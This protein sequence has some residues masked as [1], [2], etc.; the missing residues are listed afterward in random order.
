MLPTMQ[1]VALA[2]ALPDGRSGALVRGI[3]TASH[4]YSK[5]DFKATVVVLD[6]LGGIPR[7]AAQRMLQM[8]SLVPDDATRE[9][10]KD[11]LG[12]L[13]PRC[14]HTICDQIDEE[15]RDLKILGV[16]TMG[17]V[18]QAT[19]TDGRTSVYKVVNVE[20]RDLVS[21]D[22]VFLQQFDGMYTTYLKKIF[23][24]FVSKEKQALIESARQVSIPQML[25]TGADM[26][27]AMD[28]EYEA[29]AMKCFFENV[30][31]FVKLPEL[32]LSMPELL[33][34]KGGVV[35]EMTPVLGVPLSMRNS[36]EWDVKYGKGLVRLFVAMVHLGHVH[37]ELHAANI[38]VDKSKFSLVDFGEVMEL[39]SDQRSWCLALLASSVKVMRGEFA[40]DVEVDTDVLGML[41]QKV[42]YRL[43]PM[44][45]LEELSWSSGT[46][47]LKD[48]LS[49]RAGGETFK[50][51][52]VDDTGRPIYR[53]DSNELRWDDTE[54]WTFKQSVGLTSGSDGIFPPHRDFNLQSGVDELMKFIWK[55]AYCLSSPYETVPEHMKDDIL[56][57][58]ALV[59]PPKWLNRFRKGANAVGCTLLALNIDKEATISM[60][61]EAL[62]EAEIATVVDCVFASL[63]T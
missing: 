18:V 24:I 17:E 62:Q 31:P 29:R 22:V 21:Q 3:A 16:G 55:E 9:A 14:L 28:M 63:K 35:L 23:H 37:I 36:R 5:G 44:T 58:V 60:L 1:K 54:R 11:L 56:R 49:V 45:V 46:N 34:T 48:W 57:K 39:E 15:V 6:E 19:M 59:D 4:F 12:S 2:F 42:G 38:L 43:K 26:L 47:S 20:Q 41:L 33:G 7:K 51:E 50:I 40:T 25:G 27:L 8:K 30:I 32:E 61:H 52:E 13:E 53:S 10:C